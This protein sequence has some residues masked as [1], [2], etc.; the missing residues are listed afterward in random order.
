MKSLNDSLSVA[1]IRDI[2]HRSATDLGEPGHDIQ[3]GYGLLNVYKAV[4]AVLDPSILLLPDDSNYQLL[5][6]LPILTLITIVVVR[7]RK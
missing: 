1:E 2:L 3:T 7:R 5:A 6:I 4:K